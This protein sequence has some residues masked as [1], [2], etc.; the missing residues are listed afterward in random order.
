[1]TGKKRLATA[2][3]LS[4]HRIG[5]ALAVGAEVSAAVPQGNALNGGT[6]NRAGNAFPVSDLEIKMGCAQLTSRADISIRA[7]SFPGNS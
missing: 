6:A 3:R 2:L 1:M 4:T 5:R 7:G